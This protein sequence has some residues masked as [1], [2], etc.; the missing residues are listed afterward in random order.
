MNRSINGY[1]RDLPNVRDL[2]ETAPGHWEGH[3]VTG[4]PFWVVGG[5]R[6]NGSRQQWYAIAPTVFAGPE[7]AQVSSLAA[8][9]ELIDKSIKSVLRPRASRQR[10]SAHA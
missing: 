1:N 9:L 7:P 6:A 3:A 2:H 10:Q 4:D 5:T 8:A